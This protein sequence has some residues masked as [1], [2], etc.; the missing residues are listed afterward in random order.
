MIGK[1]QQFLPA[2]VVMR[3][4][5]VIGLQVKEMSLEI[6]VYPQ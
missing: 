6:K 3:V 1:V 5:E 4:V 2:V